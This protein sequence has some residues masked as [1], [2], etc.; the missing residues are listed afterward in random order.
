VEI[1]ACKT[2]FFIQ[3]KHGFADEGLGQLYRDYRSDTYNRERIHYE[4]SYRAIAG[5]VGTGD[6]EIQTRVDTLTHWLQD[7]LPT[8]SN[9][10][11]LDYG[12][13]DG[14]LLPRI[15]GQKFIYDISDIV[16]SSGIT[17]IKREAD[18][19]AYTYIQ[20]AHVLEHVTAPLEMVRKIYGWLAPGGYL[21]IELP[22]DF[23]DNR[24]KQ[25]VSGKYRG[26]VLIHEHINLYTPSS[27]SALLQS[28]GL[29][30]VSVETAL[31]DIGW[32]KATMIRALGKKA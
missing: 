30:T 21:Y 8:D 24:V 22:Q 26:T 4:P 25:L 18:L 1:Q 2:C 13:A 6:K 11:M 20:I 29:N 16:V 15:A 9:V 19:G 7:K 10:S 28:A 32:T 27:A 17:Q 31:L 14:R 23:S 3:T 5:Q 12:G